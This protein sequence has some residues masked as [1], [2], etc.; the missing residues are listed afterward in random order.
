M[1]AAYALGDE[2]EEQLA[3]MDA[4]LAHLETG[5]TI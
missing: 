1:L 3:N 2:L 5:F 4:Q